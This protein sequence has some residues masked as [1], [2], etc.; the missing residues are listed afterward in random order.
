MGPRKSGASFVSERNVSFELLER[1][2]GSERTRM[3]S[4]SDNDWTET[5][6]KLPAKNLT[7]RSLTSR[8]RWMFWIGFV[9]TAIIIG[10]SFLASEIWN[11]LPQTDGL[12]VHSPISCDLSV[13]T[14]SAFQSAFTIN[15]RGATRLTFSEAKAIV[16]VPGIRCFH[17][18]LLD[19]N[20]TNIEGSVGFLRWLWILS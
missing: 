4:L 13:T 19:E 3:S 14:G 9:T 2:N 20:A 5:N 10:L 12:I 16:C 7:R 18:Y 1:G 8:T 6:G 17:R 15:L 11:F